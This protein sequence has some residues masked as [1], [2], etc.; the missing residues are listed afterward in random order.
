MLSAPLPQDEIPR[1]YALDQSG[2]VDSPPEAEY[3]DLV[4]LASAICGTPIALL[5]IVARERQW[6]KARVGLAA[7]ETPRDISF[8]AHAILQDDLFVVED[9]AQDPRFADNPLVTADP[10]IRFYA[11]SQ[12]RS[13]D[14]QKLGTLCVIDRIPRILTAE[15]K[16][17]LEILS[18]Q[19]SQLIALRNAR[20]NSASAAR[21]R[22]E[23]FA[24][25]SHELRTPLSGVIGMTSLLADTSLD[26]DQLRYVSLIQTSAERLNGLLSNVLDYSR[27]ESGGVALDFAPTNPAEIV[28][29]VANTFSEESRAKR[30]TLNVE[31]DTSV[32][33]SA[34]LD[35]FCVRDILGQLVRNA[36]QFTESGSVTMTLRSFE[37]AGLRTLDFC[38]RDTGIGIAPDLRASILEAFVGQGTLAKGPNGLRLGLALA[39]RLARLHQGE[40]TID[41]VSPGASVHFICPVG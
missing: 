35:P 33:P 11:G 16:R 29:S 26:E 30:V 24:L 3:D 20:D 25:V 22:S 41:E 31:I 32:P 21:A 10:N 13:Q 14:G 28:E 1:L 34:R 38:V 2:I 18:R 7:A 23:F 27:L 19:A 4:A 12:L 17:A 37:S 40:I 9:A 15:Q 8:C 36:I 6:F 5:S 39:N